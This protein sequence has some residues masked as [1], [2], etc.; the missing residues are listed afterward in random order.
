[1]MVDVELSPIMYC[2]RCISK[3]WLTRD[4]SFAT[5]QCKPSCWPKKIYLKA[6]LIYLLQ[7]MHQLIPLISIKR[8]SRCVLILICDLQTEIHQRRDGMTLKKRERLGNDLCCM[9]LWNSYCLQLPL[10]DGCTSLVSPIGGLVINAN[11]GLFGLDI[12]SSLT[13]L[14]KSVCLTSPVDHLWLYS[15]Q[16]RGLL[17]IGAKV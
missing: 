1:M 9:E 4:H 15:Y 11:T 10:M 13:L 8:G 16:S 5:L 6:W 17:S 3:Q 12:Y 2:T 7:N 14:C